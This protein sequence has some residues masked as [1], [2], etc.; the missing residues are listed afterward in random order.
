M[1]FNRIDKLVGLYY[2]RMGI[3]D[4][5]NNT[6]NEGRFM[7]FVK[8]KQLFSKSIS[9]HCLIIDFDPEF[10]IRS[11]WNVFIKSYN[12][13]KREII[14][15]IVKHCYKFNILPTDQQIEN[16]LD[17]IKHRSISNNSH[18]LPLSNNNFQSKKRPR[19]VE[20][21]TQHSLC[22]KKLKLDLN[23]QYTCNHIIEICNSVFSCPALNRLTLQIKNKEQWNILESNFN[24]MTQILNDYHHLLIHHNNDQKFEIIKNTLGSCDIKKCSIICKIYHIKH[25]ISIMDKIHC[26]Y[27]HNYDIGYRISIAEQQQV[28]SKTPNQRKTDELRRII[29]NKLHQRTN[30]LNLLLHHR[31]SKKYATLNKQS[32]KKFVFGRKFVYGYPGEDMKGIKVVPIYSSLKEELL[33][34]KIAVLTN[35]QFCNEYR[36]AQSHLCSTYCRQNFHSFNDDFIDKIDMQTKYV[37]WQFSMDY[38]LSLM[39][40]CNYTHLQFEFS[41]TYRSRSQGT[42]KKT[43]GMF[44]HMGKCLKIAVKKFGTRIA[45]GNINVFYHGLTDT[46]EFSRYFNDQYLHEGVSIYGPLSTTSSF[47]VAVNFSQCLSGMVVDFRGCNDKWTQYFSMQWLSDYPYEKELLLIQNNKFYERLQINNIIGMNG[48]EYHMIFKALQFINN[49][50]TNKSE[51]NMNVNDNMKEELERLIPVII[52]LKIEDEYAKHIIQRF[53][54]NKIRI[55]MDYIELKKHL[56]LET[57]LTNLEILSKLFCNLKEIS[58]YNLDLQCWTLDK[59]ISYLS[60]FKDTTKIEEIRMVYPTN[61]NLQKTKTIFEQQLDNV[62]YCIF[63]YDDNDDEKL[64]LIEKKT[65][66]MDRQKSKNINA[67][68]HSMN[69]NR[70]KQSACKQSA[71]KQSVLSSR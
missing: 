66:V 10:P 67:T 19:N 21:T 70:S 68:E 56:F 28:G 52:E 30:A 64:I 60:K 32:F 50:I 24:V 55:T 27:M 40:Y 31:I 48:M 33:S 22:N 17:S 14:L 62:G 5:V 26:Y 13:D 49:I 61:C 39:I 63:C 11:N 37:T 6:Q 41:K 2:Q 58:I 65:K 57:L 36:K 8:Q 29:T 23:T 59:V 44:Y 45:D 16:H 9:N 69:V 53:L 1:D 7:Q 46:L 42:F 4:Y 15:F 35:E 12:I 51:N 34:N 3:L 43:H 47:A 18:K 71:C 54:R 38:L 20:P 25:E